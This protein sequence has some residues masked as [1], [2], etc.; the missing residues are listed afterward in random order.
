MC[1]CVNVGRPNKRLLRDVFFCW[2]PTEPGALRVARL[3]D[4]DPPACPPFPS[5]R[6]TG[7]AIPA[8]TGCWGSEQAYVADTLPA[9]PSPSPLLF[10]KC[11][12][13]RTSTLVLMSLAHLVWPLSIRLR[14]AQPCWE[15]VVSRLAKETQ[16]GAPK[17]ECTQVDA[18]KTLN[19][20]FSELTW[21]WPSF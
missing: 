3:A 15:A 21:R 7:T 20:N 5:S 4:Q 16:G 9:V 12:A 18:Q 8:F 14:T 10:T 2:P 17:P 13:D 1:M 6:V 11:G 19:T